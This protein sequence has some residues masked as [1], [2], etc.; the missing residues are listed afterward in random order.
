MAERCQMAAALKIQTKRAP[1]A[2]ADCDSAV[3]ER[4]RKAAVRQQRK[5][6]RDKLGM[7]QFVAELPGDRVVALLIDAKLITPAEALDRRAVNR[8]FTKI[9]WNKLF[10]TP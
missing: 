9:A 7:E 5:Y 2:A 8:A 4:R 3:V 6:R 10:L 1:P